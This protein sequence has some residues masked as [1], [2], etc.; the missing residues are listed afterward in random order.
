MIVAKDLLGSILVR[1]LDS[2]VLAGRIVET[3]AYFGL[4]RTRRQEPTWAENP[5]TS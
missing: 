1:R 3:E 5:I 2:E 4:K